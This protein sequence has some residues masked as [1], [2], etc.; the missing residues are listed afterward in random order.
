[1]SA[2]TTT[3]TP[4]LSIIVVGASGDLARRKIYPSLF[5]LYC[6]GYLPERFHIFGLA[7]TDMSLEE[8]RERIESRLTCRY[9]P[10]TSCEEKMAAFLAHCHYD[11]GQYDDVNTYLDLYVHMHRLEGNRHVNRLFYLAIPPSV[12]APAC[13]ALGNCGMVQCG[14]KDPWSRVV[15]EK[16]FGRDRASSDALVHD[17]GRVFTE[18][19]I[20]RIDHY[21]GKEM[22]QNLMV[23]RFANAVFEPL[24][25]RTHVDSVQVSWMEDLGV[26]GRGGY[27]ERYGIIRDVMQNHLLQV[28]ALVAM[29]RPASLKAADVCQAK[30]DLLKSIPPLTLEDVVIGQYDRSDWQEQPWP[31]YRDDPTVANDS[32]A[33]TYAAVHMHIDN[34]RWRGVPFL[35]RAGKALDRHLAEIRIRFKATSDGMFNELAPGPIANELVIRVQPDE[36]I[37]LLTTNKVPGLKLA[38]EPT[39]LDLTYSSAFDEE[40]PDAYESLILDVIRGNQT[41]FIRKEELAVAWDIFTPMLHRI[42]EEKIEPEPYPFGSLGPEAANRFAANLG[43]EWVP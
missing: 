5:A 11:A 18:P 14:S 35:L 20:Y 12:F 22:V 3:T 7:R 28:M 2:A 8:F 27:F 43:V 24:F 17:L 10:G 31:A 41:L 42:D 15:V 33:A 16:P 29:D 1:M 23:L 32:R 40:I 36:S 26:E 37:Y 39:R 21:L 34:E 4:P 9:A 38:V 6:Q 19:N 13:R 30:I 25:N